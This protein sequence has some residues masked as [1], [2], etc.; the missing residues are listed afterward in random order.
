MKIEQRSALVCSFREPPPPQ[1]LPLEGEE[2][3]RFIDEVFD[4]VEV[5]PGVG[6]GAMRRENWYR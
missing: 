2:L 5:R 1:T 6:H 3:D 4:T